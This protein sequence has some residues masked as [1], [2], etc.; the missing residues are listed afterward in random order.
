[1]EIKITDEIDQSL[2]ERCKSCRYCIPI[3]ITTNMI[4]QYTC[5]VN[6]VP[7]E[8]IAHCDQRYDIS[9]RRMFI[10]FGDI[11]KD[12]CSSIHYR[13]YY[14]GKEKGVSVYDCTTVDS[15]TFQIVLPM[16]FLEGAINTLTDLL[17]YSGKDK[18]V[19]LVTGDVVGYGHDNE[20]LIKNVKIVKDI[21]EEFRNQY[22]DENKMH[23]ELMKLAK[24][25][26]PMLK[27]E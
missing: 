18:K 27:E 5:G 24:E 12:E 23:N 8:F 25:N 3:K 16:P 21:T 26:E 2:I 17:F 9:R 4:T 22:G 7:C 10:R 20:P 11:P 14:C 6:G 19:Y 13:S 15:G 1:M